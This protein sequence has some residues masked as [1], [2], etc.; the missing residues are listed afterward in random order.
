ME[1][2]EKPIIETSIWMFAKLKKKKQMHKTFSNPQKT[3]GL[4]FS[5]PIPLGSLVNNP[6][7]QTHFFNISWY[8]FLWVFQ[9]DAVPTPPP[10]PSVGVFRN[11]IYNISYQKKN[12]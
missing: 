3:A 1:T 4:P 9:P 6:E 12:Q 5:S 11:I 8:Y 7:I 2:Q 10:T